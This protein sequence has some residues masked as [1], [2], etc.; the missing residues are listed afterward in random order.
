MTGNHE[1]Y[2]GESAWTVEIRR[3]GLQVLKNEHVVLEHDGASL[4]LAGVTDFSAHHYDPAQRSDPSAALRGAPADAGAKILL[5]H[6]PSSAAA[7]ASAG[8][9]VQISGHTHGGQFWPWN[10]FVHRFQPFH[11][12]P[13]SIEESMGIREPR[14]GLLGAAES[15]RRAFGNH[16][17]SLG[18]CPL[19]HPWRLRLRPPPARRLCDHI[20]APTPSVVRH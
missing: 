4:V 10:L 9:D 14:H 16:P 3:L 7:A 19:A 6:Q 12:R 15:L 1:Y 13:A 18:V 2:S 11:Q 5:A 20:P 8:F 17:H